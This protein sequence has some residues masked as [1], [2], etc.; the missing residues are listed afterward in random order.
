MALYK[1]AGV[2]RGFQRAVCGTTKLGGHCAV[3]VYSFEKHK[4]LHYETT[5]NSKMIFDAD[6]TSKNIAI[7]DVWWSFDW[8][9]AWSTAPSKVEDF[10][11]NKK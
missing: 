4:W 7:Y 1:A 2:P 9:Y 10:Q 11:I 6:D 8:K 3:H 5:A